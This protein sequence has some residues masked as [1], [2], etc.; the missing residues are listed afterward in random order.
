MDVF[1]TFECGQGGQIQ[2][3]C[4]SFAAMYWRKLL[5]LQL[6][7]FLSEQ[8]DELYSAVCQITQISF[9]SN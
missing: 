4:P 1:V 9:K 5:H 2:F 6:L 3:V 8:L 7:Q